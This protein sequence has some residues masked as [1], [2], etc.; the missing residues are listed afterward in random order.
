M[1]Q[2]KVR[3]RRTI[4]TGEFAVLRNGLETITDQMVLTILKTARTGIIRDGMDFSTA[5]CDSMGEVVCQG[6]GIALHLGSIPV[7]MTEVLRRFEGDIHPGDVFMFNDPYAGGMHLPDIFFVKPVFRGN[8]RVGF[9]VTV[10]D[11][12]DIGGMVPGG[13][14]VNAVDIYQEGIRIPPLELYSRGSRV[15]GIEEI[16]ATNVR[17]PDLFT[18]DLGACLAALRGAETE[19]LRYIDDHGYEL[20]VQFFDDVLDYS[21]RITRQTVSQWPDGT[22]PAVD[23]VDDSVSSDE[24]VR[25]ELTLQVKGSEVHIDFSGT[26]KQVRASINST[27][28]FTASAV[29]AA[30]RTLLPPEVPNNAGVFRPV[31]VL[32]PE[33]TVVNP[34]MPAPVASRGVTGFRVADVVLR[35]LADALPGEVGAA[36]EGG[37]SSFRIGGYGQAGAAFLLSDSVSGTR[38]G[39][40]KHDGLDGC[41]HFASNSTNRPIELIEAELPI[42]VWRYGLRPDSGGVGRFRGGMGLIREWEL[43]APEATLTMRADRV[44]FNPWGLEGGGDGARARNLLTR[45]GETREVNGKLH[46]A[47]LQGDR[48]LHEQASGGGYGDPFDR[49]PEAVLADWKAGRETADHALK[50][51]GVAIDQERGSVNQG[52]TSHARAEARGDESRA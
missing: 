9:V 39:T 42:R 46:L 12:G 16:V 23:Y 18:N 36:C 10:A 51:Y 7:A 8:D 29:Y 24:P 28:S 34:V 27:F 15:A 31:H 52:R 20:V 43:L 48:F 21:E 4:S 22:Y 30:I 2:P 25:I 1:S 35:A 32:A 13:R 11:F 6:P 45:D 47:M 17:L 5:I 19:L 14:P 44:K 38:G 40:A 3:E 49:D 33:G 26:S 50:C 37:P 41:A